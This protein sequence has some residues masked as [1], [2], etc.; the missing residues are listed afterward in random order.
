MCASRFLRSAARKDQYPESHL[1]RVSFV[2]RSNVGK[3]SLLN[4]LVG[5]KRLARTSSTPGRTQVINFFNVD[6]EWIFVD[7]PGYGYAKVPERVRARWAPMIEEYLLED[8]LLRLTVVIVD[9]RHQPSKLDQWMVEWL[10]QNEI[11]IQVVATKID[12]VSKNNRPGALKLIRETLGV[13]DVILFSAVTG[14]GKKDIWRT[15]QNKR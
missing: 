11:Q 8:Q 4:C 9:G 12:K 15:I 7:L 5:R 6:D 13:N 2:G 10:D 1:P 14:E 3:S